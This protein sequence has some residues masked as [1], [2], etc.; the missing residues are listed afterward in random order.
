MVPG[1]KE[2][3]RRKYSRTVSRKELK[4]GGYKD[5]TKKNVQASDGTVIIYFGQLSGG[6][7][8]TLQ[9]CLAE[10]KPYL[11]LDAREINVG[12]AAERIFGFL[13]LLPNATLNFAGPRASGEPAAYDYTLEA[14]ENFLEIYEANGL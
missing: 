12:R 1:G 13:R 9:Y 11:L 2:S 5:R 3:G 8:R 4:D 14:V 6:T 10:R 7:E